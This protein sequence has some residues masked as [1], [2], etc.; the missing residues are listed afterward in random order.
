[1]CF[2]NII[3]YSVYIIDGPVLKE[4]SIPFLKILSILIFFLNIIKNKNY[5]INK[6][7]NLLG[8]LLITS[9]LLIIMLESIILS[10]SSILKEPKEPKNIIYIILY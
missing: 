3:L 9:I 2:L 4:S 7:I 6:I 1:M 5:L 10:V 8:T